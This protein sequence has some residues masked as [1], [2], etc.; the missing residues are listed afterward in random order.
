[1]TPARDRPRSNSLSSTTAR[2]RFGIPSHCSQT[3]LALHAH[4]PSKYCIAL[5]VLLTSECPPT[6]RSLS[7]QFSK[8]SIPYE[9]SS[10]SRGKIPDVSF[11]PYVMPTAQP[12]RPCRKVHALR[13]Q[14]REFEPSSCGLTARILTLNTG[15]PPYTST[16]NSVLSHS[17]G[18]RV[19]HAWYILELNLSVKLALV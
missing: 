7:P 15:S 9:R 17:L 12:L 11:E 14:S 19:I 16:F 18:G 4:F 3:C 2:G 8:C 6:T 13:T 1:M 10:N 5:C